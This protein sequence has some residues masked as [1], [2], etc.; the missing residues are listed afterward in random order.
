MNVI[1]PAAAAA[2]AQEERENEV[3]EVPLQSKAVNEAADASQDMPV[4]NF[5]NAPNNVEV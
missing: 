1:N 2:A 5:R 3:K 4:G